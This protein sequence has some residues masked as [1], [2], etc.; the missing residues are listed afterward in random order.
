MGN[1]L[2]IGIVKDF[3]GRIGVRAPVFTEIEGKERGEE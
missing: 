3:R 1:V 2:G